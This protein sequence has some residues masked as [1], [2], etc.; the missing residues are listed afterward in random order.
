MFSGDERRAVGP[1]GGGATVVVGSG[2]AAFSAAITAAD[3]GASVLMLESTE[4][5]A[6]RRCRGVLYRHFPD[7]LSLAL[8]VFNETI[9]ALEA[10]AARGA[11]LGRLVGQLIEAVVDNAAF[12]DAVLHARDQPDFDGEARIR[13]LLAGPL[14]REQAAGGVR[15][16]LGVEDLM[17]LVRMVYGCVRT[18]RPGASPVPGVRRL[19]RLVDPGLAER[20]VLTDPAAH[21]P[22]G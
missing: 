21:P 18:Q 2:A 22:R 1:R 4:R 5:S 6:V 8:A 3:G 20:I 12:V 16:D 14:A 9:D 19:L 15:P 10:S 13:T 11:G 17:L 7:R